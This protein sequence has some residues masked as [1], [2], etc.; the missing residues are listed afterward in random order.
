MDKKQV[1]LKAGWYKIPESPAEKGYLIGSRCRSCREVFFPKRFYCANCSSP[2]IEEV[3]LST[4]GV[5]DTFTISTMTPPGSI[6]QA[7]YALARVKLP[8]GARVMTVLTDCDLGKL[9]IGMEV[10]LVIRKVKEDE[11]GNEVMAYMFKPI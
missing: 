5:I 3:A 10:E 4:R 9:D 7:P 6:M 11:E 8:E 1:P 2:D